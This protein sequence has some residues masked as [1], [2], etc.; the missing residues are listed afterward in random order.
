MSERYPEGSGDFAIQSNDNIICY[1]P[2]QVLSRVSPVFRDMFTMPN[3]ENHTDS[4][5]ST[6]KV[7]ETA[8]ILELFLTHLDP[9]LITPALDP[10]TVE[11]LLQMADKYQVKII[12]LWFEQEA[13][14]QHV[15]ALSS[16]KKD[17]FFITHPL[18]CLRLAIQ[19][20]FR[21][22]GRVVLRELAG[23]KEEVIL[24][25]QE[26]LTSF[27]FGTY[28]YIHRLRKERIKRYDEWIHSLTRDRGKIPS[29]VCDQCVQRKGRWIFKMMAA[30]RSMPTWD[31]FL[32]AYL[33][34]EKCVPCGIA[35]D[36][37]YIS[38]ITAW[39]I[40]A[41]DERNLPEWPLGLPK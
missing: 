37:I 32:N 9:N 24:E 14:M 33:D 39:K 25:S 41:L 21:E 36:A 20:D 19:F 3:P 40:L 27:N 38:D 12:M 34:S 18:T 11:D 6:V 26:T 4:A 17:A 28:L 35:W 5:F 31:R 8:T 13:T 7:A 16:A 22:F 10:N 2:S 29:K 1:F 30:I 23:C 15:S